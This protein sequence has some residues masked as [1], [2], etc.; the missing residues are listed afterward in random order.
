M[1]GMRNT[2]TSLRLQFQFDR[3][4]EGDGC[5]SI[6]VNCA[7]IGLFSRLA[8]R[9]LDLMSVGETF[10]SHRGFAPFE[11]NDPCEV[12]SGNTFNF[13]HMP[14]FRAAFEDGFLFRPDLVATKL[15]SFANLRGVFSRL[16]RHVR[17]QC[18]P[19]SGLRCRKI[20][21]LTWTI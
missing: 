18:V 2:D 14:L 12:L 15:H 3:S 13:Q 6:L 5:D 4:I 21:L 16:S 11:L 17:R 10:D 20:W 8:V 1:S 9:P 19:A 7:K